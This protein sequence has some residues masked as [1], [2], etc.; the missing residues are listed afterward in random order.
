LG[1]E[2]TVKKAVILPKML[3]RIEMGVGP[4]ENVKLVLA[5]PLPNTLE[6]IHFYTGDRSHTLP[7]D[8][9]TYLLMSAPDLHE[10][11]LEGRF[12][13]ALVDRAKVAAIAEF[14]HLRALTVTGACYSDLFKDDIRV[15]ARMRELQSLAI[16]NAARITDAGLADLGTMTGLRRLELRFIGYSHG[17]T[18]EVGL[19]N[20]WKLTGLE[21]LYLYVLGDTRHAAMA[22]CF[23]GIRSLANLRELTLKGEVTDDMLKSL[24]GLKKL[25]RLDLGKG[26][27]YTD[28]GLG[29]LVKALRGCP[30]LR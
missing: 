29:A 7:V 20:V 3:Q 16:G 23:D 22:K 18:T 26:Q 27:G 14:A 19:A 30:P 4:L 21:V 8:V 5:T 11:T 9:L 2:V 25:C 12:A 15:L 6:S 28:E 13:D 1:R 10:L 24:T 17:D